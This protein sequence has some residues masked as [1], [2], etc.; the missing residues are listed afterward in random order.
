MCHFKSSYLNWLVLSYKSSCLYWLV[1][2]FKSAYLN[3]LV[4]SF[5][6]LTLIDWF[7]GRCNLIVRIIVMYTPHLPYLYPCYMYQFNINIPSNRWKQLK[8]YQVCSVTSKINYLP[9]CV[10]V[11]KV[12]SELVELNLKQDYLVS[13]I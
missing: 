11:N 9:Q 1:L 12:K 13:E 7:S 2:S 3:W 8:Q 6:I 4:L 10:M 5:K